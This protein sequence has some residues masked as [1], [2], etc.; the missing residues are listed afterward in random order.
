MCA[1]LTGVSDQIVFLDSG[2]SEIS[3]GWINSGDYKI[4]NAVES[5][6]AVGGGADAQYNLDGI[7]DVSGGFECNPLTLDILALLGTKTGTTITFGDTLPAAGTF[8]LNADSGEYVELQDFKWGSVSID[9][10]SGEPL[11]LTFTGVGL[12]FEKKTGN[13]DYTEPS[14][15]P[16]DFPNMKVKIGGVYVGS[17]QTGNFKLDYQAKG[18]RGIENT[19]AGDIRKNTEVIT[20]VKKLELSVTIE[21]TDGVAWTQAVGGA[22]IPDS[23]SDTTVTIET[24]GTNTGTINLTGVRFRDISA[25]KANDGE[26]R[27]AIITGNVLGVSISDL[28][29]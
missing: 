12:D 1:R 6:Y 3:L 27:T 20:G 4:D 2:S 11:K 8:Q 14:G 17:V 15:E 24:G 21:I 5:K 26:V 18:Y 7:V 19:T 28:A 13:I 16:L 23:R 25:D 9:F 22:T 29:L 10:A